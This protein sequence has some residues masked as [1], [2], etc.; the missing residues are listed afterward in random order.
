MTPVS[1]PAAVLRFRSTKCFVTV[2]GRRLTIP[3][4]ARQYTI[5]AKLIDDRLQ[6]GWSADMAVK[7]PDHTVECLIKIEARRRALRHPK[8]T[9]R[10]D[11]FL[12][13][14]RWYPSCGRPPAT[15]A[16]E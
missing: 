1:P 14:G 13:C 16:K 5:S 8:N 11:P 4:A 7:T 10:S 6:H 15:R 3:E 12:P 9:P 2:D